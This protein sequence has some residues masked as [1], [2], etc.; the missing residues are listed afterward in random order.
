MLLKHFFISK[1]AHSHF[2]SWVLPPD[3]DFLLI[4]DEHENALEA[5]TWS[6]RVS[7]NPHGSRFFMNFSGIKKSYGFN[8]NNGG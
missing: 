8:I 7:V 1:L 6:R 3:I 5:N 2:T 4:V